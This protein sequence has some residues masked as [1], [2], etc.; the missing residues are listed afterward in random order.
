MSRKHLFTALTGLG[1][2]I[3][4]SAAF[5]GQGDAT[6]VHVEGVITISDSHAEN[7]QAGSTGLSLL[8]DQYAGSSQEGEG[9]SED[10]YG[11]GED[12]SGEG[13]LLRSRSDVDGQGN[14]STSAEALYLKLDG[15]AEVALLRSSANSDGDAE[16][17]GAYVNLGDGAFEAH[18]LHAG[19]AGGEGNAAVAIINGNTVLGSEA[20]G[21]IICPLALSPAAEADVVCASGARAGVLDNIDAAGGAVTGEV[22]TANSRQPGPG[23]EPAPESPA[24]EFPVVASPAPQSP[25]ARTGLEGREL[26]MLGLGA[27]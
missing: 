2:A 6:T 14:S 9:H 16:S 26:L 13:W 19:S 3:M 27:A 7:G 25:L 23:A 15:V 11:G 12:G 8:G 18:I 5:A 10:G 22:V 1:L 17:D 21:G 20:D 24:P 4:P